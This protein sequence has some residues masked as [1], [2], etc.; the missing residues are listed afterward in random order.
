MINILY[1]RYRKIKELYCINNINSIYI[2]NRRLKMH[3]INSLKERFNKKKIQT[4]IFIFSIILLSF[5]STLELDM[6][7]EYRGGDIQIML[8]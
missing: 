3:I 7:L 4:L 8:I 5:N 1:H 6:E 2:F